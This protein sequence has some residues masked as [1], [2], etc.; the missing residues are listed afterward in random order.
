MASREL[1]ESPTPFF[2]SDDARVAA[3]NIMFIFLPNR[4]S[5]PI[6]FVLLHRQKTNYKI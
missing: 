3:E 2:F 1:D 5:F 4:T 6:F